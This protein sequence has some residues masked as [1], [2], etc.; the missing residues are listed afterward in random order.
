[1]FIP[2]QHLVHR[3]LPL[4]IRQ[5]QCTVCCAQTSGH[6]CA[7]LVLG[8]TAYRNTSVQMCMCALWISHRVGLYSQ[9]RIQAMP[10][11]QHVCRAASP[12]VKPACQSSLRAAST[13]PVHVLGSCLGTIVCALHG[14]AAH[15]CAC[16]HMLPRF[17]KSEVLAPNCT[18]KPWL[19]HL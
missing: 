6:H 11:M 17:C 3:I 19:K 9:E 8:I 7:W 4:S 12:P 18:H 2:M 13:C 10:V 5:G 16:V 15:G 14:A 1:M